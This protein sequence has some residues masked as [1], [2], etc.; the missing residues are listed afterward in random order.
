MLYQNKN[1]I[2]LV[3]W[4][5]RLS[6]TVMLNATAEDTDYLNEEES[7]CS[8]IENTVPFKVV[9]VAYKGRQIAL[10]KGL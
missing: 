10:K 1:S 8:D 2:Y 9:G 6:E 5:F 4:E 3:L 7:H